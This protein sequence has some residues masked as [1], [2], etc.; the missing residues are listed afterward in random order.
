MDCLRTSYEAMR[1]Q[2][3]QSRTALKVVKDRNVVDEVVP[4][5]LGRA[6]LTLL[7]LIIFV[8]GLYF[9]GG[10]SWLAW[11]GGSWYFVL[12]GVLFMICGVQIARR[13]LLGVAILTFTLLF[14]VLWAVWEVGFEFWPLVSRILAVALIWAAVAFSMPLLTRKRGIRVISVALG[15]VVSVAI[16]AAAVSA[17]EPKNIIRNGTAQQ[18][19]D[20]AEQVR[21][22]AT[23]QPGL[24]IPTARV[25]RA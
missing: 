12:A 10:G 13:R 17:F 2:A 6:W 14:T 4:G 20:G 19:G 22:R 1:E 18:A 11:L 7:G 9:A 8:A 23:G 15:A 16:V 5:R 21:T 24:A 3:P 25:S